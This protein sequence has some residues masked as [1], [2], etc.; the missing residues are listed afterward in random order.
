MEV[1]VGISQ[2]AP[3]DSIAAHADGSYRSNLPPRRAGFVS[4]RPEDGIVSEDGIVQ[5]TFSGS[6]SSQG[7]I[8]FEYV[9]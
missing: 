5:Q 3:G 4:I 2:R 7:H 1:D 9:V 8:F 6:R